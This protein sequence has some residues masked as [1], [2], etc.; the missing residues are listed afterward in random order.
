VAAASLLLNE[1]I[2]IATAAGGLLI[3]AGVMIVNRNKPFF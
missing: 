1:P 3:I 2:L